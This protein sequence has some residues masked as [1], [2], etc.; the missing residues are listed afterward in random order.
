MTEII[1]LS[2]K[3]QKWLEDSYFNLVREMSIAILAQDGPAVVNGFAT[4]HFKW[5][6]S[7][8]DKNM[9]G[10]IRDYEDY[11]ERFKHYLFRR[12]PRDIEA[13]MRFMVSVNHSI[14]ILKGMSQ[15]EYEQVLNLEI[16]GRE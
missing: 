11:S 9:E 12:L 2:P 10:R 7:S 6:K 8:F 1:Q 5:L 3:Q 14:S 13:E 4:K 16:R 15:E